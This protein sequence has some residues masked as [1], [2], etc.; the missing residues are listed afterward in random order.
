MDAEGE[1]V[2]GADAQS[3][4]SSGSNHIPQDEEG[5]QLSNGGGDIAGAGGVKELKKQD[6]LNSYYE[7]C[8][9]LG[10][11]PHRA[12][13]RYLEETYDENDSLEIII[14]GNDKLNFSNR[15][16]DEQV[17][18]LCTS[19]EPYA[20]FIEDI[21][22]RYNEISDTGARYL[23]DLISQSHRLLGLNI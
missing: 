5:G 3:S 15:L 13:I 9:G 2:Q 6:V 4:I 10:L 12:F 1:F 22:L 14:Q 16:S 19:L 20:M 17:M 7:K 11:Q 21:D 8:E 23:G 18:A